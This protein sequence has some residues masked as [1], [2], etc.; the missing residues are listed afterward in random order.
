[1]KE[2]AHENSLD[3]SIPKMALLMDAHLRKLKQSVQMFRFYNLI[4][5]F[6][7]LLNF[8]YSK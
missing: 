4:S 8:S 1:D 3:I 7:Y 6:W 5:S 2:K